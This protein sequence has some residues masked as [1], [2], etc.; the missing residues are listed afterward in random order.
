MKAEG[1][2]NIWERY[3]LAALAAVIGAGLLLGGFAI[4]LAIGCKAATKGILNLTKTLSLTVKRLLIK[5][6]DA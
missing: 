6:E 2:R 1:V 3:K 4:L 5:K